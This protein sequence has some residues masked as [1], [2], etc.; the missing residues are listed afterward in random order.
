MGR[1]ISAT[2]PGCDLDWERLAREIFGPLGG[3]V[4][5]GAV[6]AT[7]TWTVAEASVGG[8]VDRRRDEVDRLLT[9]VREVGGFRNASMAIADELGWLLDHQVTAP[10]LL[11]WSGCYGERQGG[12]PGPC[13]RAGEAARHERP[14]GTEQIVR[15]PLPVRGAAWL[16]R[17]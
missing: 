17:L 6:V 13:P 14:G 15:V 10:S 4:E 11:L 9:T 5:I 1:L 16:P 2:G 8:L 12:L 7:G 3:I